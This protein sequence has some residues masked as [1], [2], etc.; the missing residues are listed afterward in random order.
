MGH[1][2]GQW[3]MGNGQWTLSAPSP[4]PPTPCRGGAEW[5]DRDRAETDVSGGEKDVRPCKGRG[6]QT[7]TAG[8]A[9]PQPPRYADFGWAGERE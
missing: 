2:R 4:R 5:R 8:P 6:L 3:T 9:G 1:R 7:P